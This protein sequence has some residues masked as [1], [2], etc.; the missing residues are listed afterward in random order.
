MIIP[1]INNEIIDKSYKAMAIIGVCRQA[2]D[3]W[4]MAGNTCPLAGDIRLAL[5]V[6]DDLVS[7][8]HDAMER[9]HLKMGK[10]GDHA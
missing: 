3:D 10:G 4:P 7:E 1:L 6:A 8:V 9:T 2:L 5:E